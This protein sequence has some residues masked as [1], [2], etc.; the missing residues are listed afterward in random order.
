MNA[1]QLIFAPLCAVLAVLV[2][3]R[4]SRERSGVRHTL[5]WSAL[6]IAAAV[7]IWFPAS[8]TVAARWLG[9]GR[10]ADLVFYA[11]VL[12]GLAACLYF[13]QR[14]RRLEH[15]CTE[16]VRREAIRQACRGQG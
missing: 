1:F 16:L 6:W 4:G 10:G 11:A 14:C 13:Y 2:V 9:I 15:A 8:V 7:G 3:L 5:F 12:A